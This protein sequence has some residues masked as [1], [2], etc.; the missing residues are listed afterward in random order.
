MTLLELTIAVVVIVITASSM[1]GHLAV[2]FRGANAERDR[3]FAYNAAQSILSEIHAFAADSL[4]E[5]QDIDAFDD[6]ANMWPNLT[7]V[8]ASDG[9]LLAPDHPASRNVMRDGHWVWTRQVS[10]APVPEVQNNSLRYVTVRIYKRKDD[11]DSTLVASV[12]S[13]VNGLAASYPTAQVFDVFF[14]A[15]ENIPGW[16]VHMES[17]RPFMESIVTE[18]EGK[19]P[20]LEVRTHWITKSGYGRDETYR[21]YVNDTVD[22]ETQV[23]WVYYYPGRMPDGNASTY[24]YVPSAM[25]AR[26]VTESGEVNGYDDVSNPFPYAFADHFNHAMRYPRAKEFHDARVASMHARAQEIL[27]AKS[28]GTKPPDEFTDMSEE[29]TLQ[30]FLEDLNANPATYQHAVVLNLHGELL[31]L[32]PLRNYSDAAKDPAGLPGVRVVTHSEELRTARPGGSGA[33]DVKLRVYAYVDDPWTWTGIDRLPETRP[34]ALQIMDVDLLKDNGSGKLWDDVVI[35]NLRGGVDVDGTSEYFP[36]DESGKAGDGSLKS[37]EMYYEASFVDPGPGQRKFT[38]LKL[39]NTPVVSPPV[40]ADGVTRGL[41]ANER[42]RLYGLEYVP[43]CAG[44]SKDFSKDLYASGDGPKNTARWVITVPA[45]VWDDKRFTDLSSPPNYY[46]PRDTSEPDHLLTV[47]TRIWDPSLSDPYSTG[48]TPRGA[49]VDFVEPHNFS[50]T[51]TWWA[52]S[53]DDV[54][55]TERFQFR[56]DPRHNP[57]KDLLDGDPDFPNGYNWF[58]DN[59]SSGTENAVADFA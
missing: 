49:I 2:T 37:G 55:F 12:S 35:E 1:I 40:T 14:I 16:W 15:I 34:I 36:L 26:F 21:P 48:T 59:L 19:N 32:P 30:M 3:V 52:D 17:I 6:G 45:N 18:I 44:S 41:L 11:G 23:D 57:Y 46:D 51:Y 8:E 7:V 28:N 9:A 25:R 38:L 5:P 24:Y 13:I 33:S 56:G 58:F 20:G 54:P 27:L 31:P 42:S 22:S 50:E 53:P 4:D 43:S 39:Y 47:R 10:V 29:P